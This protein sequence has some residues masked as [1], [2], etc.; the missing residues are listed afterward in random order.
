MICSLLS[1]TD[2][3]FMALFLLYFLKVARTKI[4][5][6]VVAGCWASLVAQMLKNLPATWETR[7]QSLGWKDPLEEGMAT[8]SSILVWRIPMDRGAWRATGHGIVRSDTTERAR[9]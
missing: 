5:V 7:V 1:M 2:S 6:I 8:H 3:S 4:R 9:Y